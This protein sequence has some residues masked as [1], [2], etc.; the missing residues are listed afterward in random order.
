MPTPI[1]INS[2]SLANTFGEWLNGTNDTI[3]IINTLYY[4]DFTKP[5]GTLYL[6]NPGVCIAVQNT[7]VFTGLVDIA[8]AGS[9]LVRHSAEVQNTLYLT[10]KDSG[11]PNNLV[12]SANG[13]ANIN[14]VNIVGTGLSANVANNMLIG[15]TL[16]VT[17][18]TYLSANLSVTQDIT[19][20]NQTIN[21]DQYIGQNQYIG[22]I[23]THVNTVYG[24]STAQYNNLHSNNNIDT[25]TFNAS[26]KTFAANLISNTSVITPNLYVSNEANVNYLHSNTNIVA[27]SGTIFSSVVSANN[28]N[29]NTLINGESG[30]LIT[31]DYATIRKDLTIT[32]NLI[33]NSPSIYNSDT[34]VL[35]AAQTTNQNG[36]F[37]TYRPLGTANAFIR[38]SE[39]NKYWDIRD[40]D[41]GVDGS[42]YQ[43]I[44][45]ANDYVSMNSA[46]LTANTN[47]K[48]YVDITVSTANTDMKN[49]VDVNVSTANTN[50]KNYVD[51]N[52]STA[53]TNMKNY[54]D[55]NVLSLQSQISANGVSTNSVIST[56]NTNMK[57]YVD[58]SK[59]SSVL[60]T[61]SRISTSG[62][63]TPTLD[64]VS[65]GTST[66]R[67]GGA[68]VIPTF[69]VDTYGR[70]TS[71]ANTTLSVPITSGGTG[72]SSAA[73]ALTN[74]LPTGTTSGY[75]LT[76]GGPGTFYWAVGGSGGTGTIPG[77][78][79]N[80]TR[81]FYTATSNQTVFTTPTYTPGA[82]QLRVYIG[83]VRQYSAD[84]TETN[85]T[86]VTLVTGCST[87]DP[88]MVEVDGYVNNPYYANNITFT[89]PFGGIVSTANTIQLAIQDVE[90]RKSTLI[91]PIFTGAPLAPTAA[92]STSN[93]MIATTSF[94]ATSFAPVA[95]PTF[96]G[97]PLAPTATSGTSNT[98]IATTSF[99][100]TG[101]AANSL[102]FTHQC[103]SLGV[104]TAASGTTGEILAT[105]NI[106]AYYSDERL[107]TKLG[108]IENAL[109]KVNQLSGFYHE[110][111]EIAQ[112]LGYEKYREV[113]VSAQEV[114][115]VLPEIVAP[116][117][118][119]PQYLT[120]RYERLTPLLIEAIKELNNKV[121]EL[122][123]L[124]DK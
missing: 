103:K 19:G 63:L 3:N 123:K 2:V 35:N 39:S 92:A 61:A 12:L 77:T 11:G 112:S 6:S 74:L 7:A 51:V 80:S 122:K 52:V 42:S 38:W 34:F 106:T 28:I 98:M 83:G 96:T 13:V 54:V 116:A 90:T 26:G 120:V 84:Y 17:G 78:T 41:N 62:G 36:Y 53:N 108:P 87:G 4:G 5:L 20:N 91:S 88:V 24:Y 1:L 21:Y 9:L 37:G 115:K 55:V 22:N 15:G 47:M 30:S 50:M 49:Y 25:I 46:A 68:L 76:T 48:N 60:G 43:R 32:G 99:V 10:N 100:A 93:T 95:S 71:I 86:T 67:F 16:S 58:S 70:I 27:N 109:D 111:N 121:E 101:F 64:L 75:V 124:I 40:I 72:A 18:N 81:L 65:T 57:N 105:N 94:V 45:T 110:A 117:P 73:G 89:A 69:V 29:F 31:I 82:S 97:A 102:S 104:G 23:S 114:Q 59:V 14:Y 119:D 113:G 56:A 44:L 33:I 66:G 79:I 118:I 85:T 8:G 107:K